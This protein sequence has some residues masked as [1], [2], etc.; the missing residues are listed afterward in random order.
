LDVL[1]VMFAE[2]DGGA[3]LVAAMR[4]PEGS[5]DDVLATEAQLTVRRFLR[6]ARERGV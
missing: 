5:G 4:A 2:D 6:A 1:Q 3:R